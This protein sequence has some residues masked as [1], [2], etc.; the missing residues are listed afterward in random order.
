MAILSSCEQGQQSW[1]WPGKPRSVFTHFLLEAL[2]GQA[3]WSHKG[4]VTVSDANLYVTNG[5]KKWAVDNSRAQ[6]PRIDQWRSFLR[7]FVER[8]NRAVFS[9][10]SLDYTVELSKDELNVI[11][12]TIKPMT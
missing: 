12:V 4:F 8:G 5:V 9:C 10:R 1:E 7:P 2:R 3:D 11:R 6:T